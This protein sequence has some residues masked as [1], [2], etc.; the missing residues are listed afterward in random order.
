[1]NHDH[2]RGA[3]SPDIVQGG[4]Q[5][6]ATAPTRPPPDSRTVTGLGVIGDTPVLLSDLTLSALS[7]ASNMSRGRSR[8][9][10]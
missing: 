3:L 6:L 4:S 10:R 2:A 7:K 8:R 5:A 1:M 9:S